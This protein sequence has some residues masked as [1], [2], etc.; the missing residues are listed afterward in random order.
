MLYTL[1]MNKRIVSCQKTVLKALSG[2]MDNFYLAG[3]TALSLF[4]FQHRLSVDL[5]FFTQNF[6][7]IFYYIQYAVCLTAGNIKDFAFYAWSNS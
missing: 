6:I 3:G 4:Y 7:Y 1:C 5:D 2:R